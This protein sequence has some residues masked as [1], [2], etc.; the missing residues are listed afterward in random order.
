MEH[1]HQLLSGERLIYYQNVKLFL[2]TREKR[3]ENKLTIRLAAM[4]TKHNEE[5]S[6]RQRKTKRKMKQQPQ[7]S[8]W[9]NWKNLLIYWRNE[10]ILVK[11]KDFCFVE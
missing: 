8:Q 3:Q 9:K 2:L 1:M 5:S 11:N 4:K 10:V 6:G 7:Y